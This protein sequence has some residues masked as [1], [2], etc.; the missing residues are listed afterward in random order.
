MQTD[1][2][3]SSSSG[4]FSPIKGRRRSLHDFTPTPPATTNSGSTGPPPSRTPHQIAASMKS[5]PSSPPN[6]DALPRLQDNSWIGAKVSPIQSHVDDDE[7]EDN[8]YGD[9]DDEDEED[10]AVMAPYR[11]ALKETS[12]L[13]A[14]EE[15]TLLGRKMVTNKRGARMMGYH[16]QPKNE[17][18]QQQQPRSRN[19]QNSRP[20]FALP[21]GY[22]TP[23][24]DG[25]GINAEHGTR[26]QGYHASLFATCCQV[27]R[28][29][30]LSRS[31]LMVVPFMSGLFIFCVAL[32]DAFMVY[33][34]WRRGVTSTYSLA[35][36]LPLMAPSERS[37][38]LFGAFSPHHWLESQEY[39][40]SL[41]AMVA[42]SSLGEW[43]LILISWRWALPSALPSSTHV[44]QYNHH[45][46][47]VA[48]TT[49]W[50][51]WPT[52][53]LLSALTGQLW[54]MAF[55]MNSGNEGGISGC[56]GW[57]TAGVL[58]AMGMLWP[59]RRFGLFVLA[60]ALVLVNLLQA[61]SY[62]SST[63]S[64]FGVIGASFFGWSWCG[65]WL[66]PAAT[67]LESASSGSQQ[68][69]NIHDDYFYDSDKR[70][71]GTRR[72]NQHPSNQWGFWNALSAVVVVN[73]WLLPILY[74][75][76]G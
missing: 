13:G 76:Y 16:Q 40:R 37:L 66:K 9:D 53:H 1:S 35:W 3:S 58:C 46:S 67:A 71:D 70:Y 22:P 33:L 72:P 15:T 68:H 65:M 75:L 31:S 30:F 60:I 5:P 11:K 38:L 54:M 18:Q 63:G 56:S 29:F 55:T 36:S 7:D 21:Q 48:S 14:T 73:L 59:D 49:I 25:V 74:M 26:N 69:H 39:W 10:I 47:V 17:Q 45:N 4:L 44:Q 50:L 61:W 24:E 52:E 27:P 6:N 20:Q 62:S 19:Q 34:L 42:T 57:G 64:V 43:G 41:S 28:R 2:D 12:F 51:L 8:L 23:L 32:H